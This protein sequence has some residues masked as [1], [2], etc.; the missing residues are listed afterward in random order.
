MAV[1]AGALEQGQRRPIDL[2][3]LEQGLGVSQRRLDM[4][5]KT[6]KSHRK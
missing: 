6:G 3:S 4:K 5:R 2:S 1:L